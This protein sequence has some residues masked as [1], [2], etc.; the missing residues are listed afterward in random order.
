MKSGSPLAPVYD[1]TQFLN[2]PR[3]VA[4]LL[5][6]TTYA[7]KGKVLTT[8][9]HQ[10]MN[11][12]VYSISS[13]CAPHTP[14]RPRVIVEYIYSHSSVNFS[15]RGRVEV[16]PKNEEQ[17]NKQ[18]NDWH[19]FSKSITLSCGTDDNYAKDSPHS[20]WIW[21]IFSIMLSVQHLEQCYG[22]E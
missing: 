8:S 11:L 9:H 2:I 7:W 14:Q 5:W 1:A 13:V 3:L 19:T 10:T 17:T 6:V 22:Y 15:L 21:E 18:T 12:G 20:V 16:D 4:I